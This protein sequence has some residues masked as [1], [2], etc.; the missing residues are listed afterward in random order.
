MFRNVQ[1]IKPQRKYEY[2]ECKVCYFPNRRRFPTPNKPAKQSSWRKVNRR[3]RQSR[4][5]RTRWRK[6]RRR[7]RMWEGGDPTN[8]FRPRQQWWWW[9]TRN[10]EQQQLTINRCSRPWPRTTER[11]GVSI[12]SNQCFEPVRDTNYWRVSF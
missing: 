8:C 11:A 4:L 7:A 9:R 5:K 10:S 2:L 1:K 3:V 6:Q 12:A